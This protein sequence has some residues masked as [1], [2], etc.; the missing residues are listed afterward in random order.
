MKENN[1]LQ[2]LKNA[3]DFLTVYFSLTMRPIWMEIKMR[4]REFIVGKSSISIYLQ[5]SRAFA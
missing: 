4:L 1:V 2:I 5:L 3:L